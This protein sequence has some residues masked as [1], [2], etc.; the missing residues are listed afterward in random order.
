M[1]VTEFL[2]KVL[3]GDCDAVTTALDAQPELID[4]RGQGRA[5]PGESS[6]LNLA[7]AGGLRDV[8]E[9]LI[10]RGASLACADSGGV[11]PVLYPAIEGHRDVAQLLIERGAEVDIFSAAA[12]G[13]AA[14]VERLLI[15]RPERIRERTAWGRTPLHTCRSVEVAELL[16]TAGADLEAV[17]DY[18][19]TPLA[20]ICATGRHKGVR[21]FLKQRGARAEADNIF[22]ACLF[23]DLEAVKRFLSADP[24]VVNRRRS[25]S[26]DLDPTSIGGTPLYEAAR[27][28]EDAIVELL[29]SAGADVNARHATNGATPLHVSAA[30]GHVDTA[31]LLLEAGADATATDTEFGATPAAW[32]RFFQQDALAERLTAP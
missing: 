23:G 32:A 20:W 22:A 1:T 26:P 8:V 18:E 29:F 27:R 21:D 16:L 2:E 4:R 13:D 30:M 19:S 15:E 11:S 12:L 10:D 6:A 17:D 28:G 31:L 5:W 7:S 25:A 3:A 14:A 24:D 9:L